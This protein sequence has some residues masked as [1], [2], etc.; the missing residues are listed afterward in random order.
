MGM[1]PS[2]NDQQSSFKKTLQSQTVVPKRIVH[3]I[4]TL[5]VH[6]DDKEQ[7]VIS[8]H[9]YVHL[10]PSNTETGS[11]RHLYSYIYS[12]VNYLK[13]VEKVVSYDEIY[14]NLKIDVQSNTELLQNLSSN[15]KVILD[16]EKRTLL[17]KPH[18][19]I[20]SK[21]ELVALLINNRVD[22]IDY[23]ELKESYSRIDPIIEELVNSRIVLML[24][25]EKKDS[26]SKVLFYNEYPHITPVDEEFRSMWQE[27]SLPHELDISKELEAAG[28]KGIEVVHQ[29]KRLKRPSGS[30]SKSSKRKRPIKITNT[31]LAGIVDFDT[32]QRP[33]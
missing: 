19:S 4:N 1:H 32:L 24:K 11:Q 6:A 10:I 7:E 14:E 33:Y 13:L 29:E 2:L 3:P 5:N 28:F 18:F 25:G 30:E 8:R 26:N 22:G 20:K 9:S 27:I 12:I 15:P 23:E 16:T 31:H 17:F 21:E